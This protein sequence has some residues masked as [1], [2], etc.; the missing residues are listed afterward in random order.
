MNREIIHPA[1]EQHWLE[2]RTKDITSTEISA[3]F[4]ISPYVTEFE[5]WHRHHDNLAVEFQENERM[6]WGP[7]L[8][9]SI[10]AGIAE[11]N[12]WLVRRMDEYIRLPELRLG[13][14]FDFSIEQGRMT[15]NM[16]DYLGLLEI[17]N[18]DSL[19]LRD[20]WIIDGENIE[21]PPHIELQVQ[22][23]L[24][25]SG[26]QFAYIGALVGGNR[27]ILIRR[28]PSPEIH[29]AIKQKS[30]AV[31]KSID[32]GI[33]PKPDFSR[34]ADFVSKLYGY[35]EPNKILDAK[36]NRELE[37]LMR[38][39]QDATEDEKA[40]AIKKSS[41]K[42][43]ILTLIG[44]AEKVLGDGWSISA[45]LIGEVEMKFT[46]KAYRNFKPYFKKEI[47]Q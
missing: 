10:A 7:R 1:S 8:Q 11:D 44:D 5:I 21:A 33:E 47:T 13:A 40:A 28:E 22:H 12:G 35:A 25:V 43:E 3:L 39:Y 16:P 19:Q 31:W 14:S 20:K 17:K 26:R 38:I 32:E 37:G 24:L 9:D 23:Q 42:A 27:V 41:A 34:D 6:K 15:A 18:I 30:A 36:D 2:L 4:G 45:G 46:R 29:E